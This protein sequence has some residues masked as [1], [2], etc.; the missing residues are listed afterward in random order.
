[1]F[2]SSK[3][4]AGIVAGVAAAR[5]PGYSMKSEEFTRKRA[6]RLEPP[7]KT[8]SVLLRFCCLRGCFL[9]GLAFVMAARAFDFFRR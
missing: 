9:C 6:T 3:T 5:L 7:C 4:I 1:V 8:F 2:F